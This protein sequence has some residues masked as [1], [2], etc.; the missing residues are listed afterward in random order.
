MGLYPDDNYTLELIDINGKIVFSENIRSP[1]QFETINIS[2][3]SR[4]GYLA[5]LY[6]DK[7]DVR[8]EI[9]ID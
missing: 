3:L 5:N 7:N 2:K 9:F 4:G 6:A 8:A 1:K